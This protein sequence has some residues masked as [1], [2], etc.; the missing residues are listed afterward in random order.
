MLWRIDRTC[1]KTS[2]LKVVRRSGG[3]VLFDYATPLLG[4]DVVIHREGV[5]PRVALALPK[6]NTMGVRERESDTR[7]EA[8]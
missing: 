7:E 1:I 5:R 8:K 6:G 4:V 3:Q 2:S